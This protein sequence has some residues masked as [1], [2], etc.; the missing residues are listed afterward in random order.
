MTIPYN[1]SF[2]QSVKYLR[3]AFD[4]DEVDVNNSITNEI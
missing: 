2:I 1:A 4:Y 3:E